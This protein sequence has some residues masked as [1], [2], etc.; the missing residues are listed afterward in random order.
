MA[1]FS[2]YKKSFLRQSV[3]LKDDF[4]KHCTDSMDQHRV[5]FF[6]KYFKYFFAFFDIRMVSYW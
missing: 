2:S 6:G 1:G 4:T 5:L 3:I